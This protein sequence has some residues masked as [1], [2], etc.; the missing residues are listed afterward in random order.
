[1]CDPKKKT[2]SLI[3]R[4]NILIS[5]SDMKDEFYRKIELMCPY[6]NIL[7]LKSIEPWISRIMRKVLKN[8]VCKKHILFLRAVELFK[9]L[10]INKVKIEKIIINFTF[11]NDILFQP[12][13][14]QWWPENSKNMR[15]RNFST[16]FS[17]YPLLFKIHFFFGNWITRI[18]FSG[19]MVF[20]S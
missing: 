10:D 17:C 1:M 19:I 18:L 4:F 7:I 8:K 6:F 13:C 9:A 12:N 20:S 2:R 15:F 3:Q 5:F 14:L 16:T 11:L